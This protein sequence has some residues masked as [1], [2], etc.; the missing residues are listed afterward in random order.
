M[1]QIYHIQLSLLRSWLQCKCIYHSKMNISCY[2]SYKVP[3]YIVK[4]LSSAGFYSP[5]PIQ[6]QAIPVML[7]VS[8]ISTLVF[9]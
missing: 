2:F 5:T 4:N 9:E 7:H 8:K 1:E 6:M 3:S